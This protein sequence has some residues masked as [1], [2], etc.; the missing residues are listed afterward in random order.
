MDTG[1]TAAVWLAFVVGHIAIAAMIG[2]QPSYF[3]ELFSTKTRYSGMAIGHELSS[4]VAG[5]LSPVVATALLASTGHFLPV[6]LLTVGMALVATV[7]LVFFADGT[8]T[9]TAQVPSGAD[10]QKVTGAK[11]DVETPVA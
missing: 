8:T 7:A 4:A 3:A 5:G 1:N 11:E 6:A 9:D 10:A 2:V